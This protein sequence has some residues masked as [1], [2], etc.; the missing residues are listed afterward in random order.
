MSTILDRSPS[1]PT[2]VWCENSFHYIWWLMFP[3]LCI[4]QKKEYINFEKTFQTNCTIIFVP[5]SSLTW[6][7]FGAFLKSCIGQGGECTTFCSHSHSIFPFGI[8]CFFLC[9]ITHQVGCPHPLTL[10]DSLHLWSTY[11]VAPMVQN[12]LHPMMPFEMF[13]PSSWETQGFMFCMN[14]FMYFSNSPFNL[15][16]DTLAS[17]HQLMT[18]APWPM[19]SLSIPFE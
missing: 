14:K 9:Y 16:V 17:C 6:F 15:L 11:F 2:W 10:I 19:M 3:L 18:F 5:P 13:S 7:F 1:E 12:G 8:K 4:L